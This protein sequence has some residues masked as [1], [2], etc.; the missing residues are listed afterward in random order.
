MDFGGPA[1][2]RR[3]VTTGGQ[4]ADPAPSGPIAVVD[5]TLA[6][7]LARGVMLLLIAL[8]NSHYFLTGREVL[9]G[10]PVGGPPP[11]RAV[12]W[13]LSTFVDGRAYPFFGLMFGYG[14]A[15]LVRR[16][17][18]LGPRGVQ[19]MLRRRA[20][21]LLVV[22]LLHGALLFVGDILAA[23]GVLLLLG[24]WTVRWR[25]RWL[26]G[27]AA[28]ALLLTGLPAAG[29]L[30]VSPDPPDLSMLPTD[31]LVMLVERVQV[32]PWIALLGPIGFVCPFF[33][34]L[35]AGRRRVLDHLDAARDRA[36]ARRDGRARRLR[37][38]RPA[39]LARGSAQHPTTTRSRHLERGRAAGR[40]RDGAALDDL[41]PGGLDRGLH[42]LPARLGRPSGSR[43]DGV[44]RGAQVAA[45]RRAGR[46]GGCRGSRLASPG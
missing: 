1:P 24:A 26:L 20:L 29:S 36:P 16:N 39:R 8:A 23:Y 27:G 41:L 18:A 3:T 31:P 34:G 25:D 4:D 30:S 12:T 15:Q 46:P 32:Q 40:G 22:G 38:R 6:P 33:V 9:G 14:V 10:Y 19:V 37:L 35:W 45:H 17:E 13:L 11:D 2:W 44:A 7:D 5:R 21:V 43:L 42:A 28:V